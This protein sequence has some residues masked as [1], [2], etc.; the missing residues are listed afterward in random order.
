M[1]TVSGGRTGSSGTYHIVGDRLTGPG[2]FTPIR[3]TG[4][5]DAIGQ[6]CGMHGGRVF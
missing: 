3:C 6:I 2:L 5:E 4:P 1:I